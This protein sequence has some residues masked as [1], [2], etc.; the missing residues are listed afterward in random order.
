MPARLTFSA[1]R[2][3]RPGEDSGPESG[4][5]DAAANSAGALYG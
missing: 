5:G 1:R 4:F 3:R 2:P